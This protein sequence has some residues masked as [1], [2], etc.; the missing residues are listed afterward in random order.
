M[1]RK[2]ILNTLLVLIVLS[3]LGIGGLV[4]RDL[5]RTAADYWE[6]A[7]E[8][9]TAKNYT[10][11]VRYMTKAANGG[12]AAAQYELA[13]LY[14]AGDKIPENRELAKNYMTLATLSRLPE[15]HYVMAV[16]MERGYFEGANMNQIVGHY[17]YA[18]SHGI[19][20]A[21]KT[22]VVLYDSGVG[23]FPYNLKRKAYWMQKLKQAGNTNAGK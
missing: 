22:L 16:W 10:R 18:A 3:L 7:Q 19:Q 11:A 20:N 15:A 9:M 4:L 17:E 5:N 13:L 6:L 2:V 23:G 14:D 21:M 12:I 1:K 8:Q